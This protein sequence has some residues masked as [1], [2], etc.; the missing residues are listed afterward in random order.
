MIDNFA[1]DQRGIRSDMFAAAEH[2]CSRVSSLSIFGPNNTASDPEFVE[3]GWLTGYNS[4]N[5]DYY[6]APTPFFA[7]ER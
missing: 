3:W 4:G 7:W 1:D 6:H 2:F 5:T